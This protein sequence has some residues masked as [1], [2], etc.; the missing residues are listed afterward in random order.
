MNK[1][2]ILITKNGP[3]IVTGNLPLNKEIAETGKSGEPEKWVETKKYHR[4][5]TYALRIMKLIL[6]AQKRRQTLYMK[7]KLK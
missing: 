3:Y 1:P 7:M 2:K 5:E 6:T 4:K